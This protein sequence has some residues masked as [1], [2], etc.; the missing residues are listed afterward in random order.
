[1]IPRSKQAL[2][3][4]NILVYA[5]NKDSPYHKQ[6]RIILEQ[7]ASGA[8]NGVISI[9]NILEFC[10]VLTSVKL[11]KNPI[12]IKHVWKLVKNLIDSGFEIIYP[13]NHVL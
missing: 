3:D 13:N 2:I 8:I 12:S 6:A 11:L 4:T 9:Q 1:M 7:V 5:V 10:S